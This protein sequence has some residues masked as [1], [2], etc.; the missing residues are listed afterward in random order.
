MENERRATDPPGMVS[1]SG[2][3][4]IWVVVNGERR[5]APSGS[6]LHELVETLGFAGRPVAV[7]VDGHVVSRGQFADRRLAG[8]ERI[9]IVTFVGG[10]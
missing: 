4:G 7:E 8:G 9:E 3:A 10:G 5:L 2:T 6:S 1:A